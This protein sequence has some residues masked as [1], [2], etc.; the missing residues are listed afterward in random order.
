MKTV[1]VGLGAVGGL[2]AARLAAAGHEVAALARGATLAAVR[3]H[4]LVLKD[5][6]GAQSHHI[7]VSDH[8]ADLGTP[9]L[10][11]VALKAPALVAAARSLAPLVAPDTVVLPAMNGVPWWFLDG[12]PLACVDP[13]GVIADTLPRAQVLGCVVHLSSSCP[14]P[15]VVR[16]GFGNRLIVGE[17]DGSLS[18]R[19][20]AVVQRLSSAGFD[21]E[22]STQI[23]Q[24]LWYKLWG[25]MTM[26]PVSALTGADAAAILDDELLRA[27]MARAMAEAAA[28]GQCIGCPIAQSAE[29]RMAVTRQLGAFRTSML[30]DA[31]AGR[32]L[33]LDALVGAVREIGTRLGVPTPNTDAL[34]ALTRLMGRVRGLY[35]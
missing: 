13:C 33:E 2:I 32:T 15:G 30:Q 19:L 5:A 28:I 3:E 21:V 8:A 18:P 7:P 26:N 16:H 35:P 14:R 4:G 10:L 22:P 11:V 1:V 17:P 6:T 31:D 23:R 34:L 20:Q 25:N 12:P 9:D 24:D 27:F 29:A